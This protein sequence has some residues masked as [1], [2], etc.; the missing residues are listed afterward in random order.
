MFGNKKG[1]GGVASTL[2]LFI[3]VVGVSTGLVV[4]LKN[5][6][7]QTQDSFSYQNELTNNKIRT[8]LSIT[9]VYYNTT[10]NLTYVYV[11]NVGGTKL[12]PTEFDF[13]VDGAYYKDF[14]ATEPDD[15]NTNLSLLMPSQTVALIKELNL[16]SGTHKIKVVSE[17]GVGDED[18]FNI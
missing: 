3:A 8:S 10:S 12:Q 18:L 7:F 4:A 2:I 16:T 17:F 1:F 13:F 5:Y 11:K 15:F 9:H 14:N 6:V